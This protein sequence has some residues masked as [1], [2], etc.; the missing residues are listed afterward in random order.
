[1]AGKIRNA[2]ERDLP[3]IVEIYNSSIPG[4]TATADL[5]PVSVDDRRSWFDSHDS[6][7]RPILVLEVD[8][9]IAGWASLTDFVEGRP[10][11]HATAE[12]SI[13][14]APPYQAL[15]YGRQLM[16]RIIEKCPAL[17]IDSLL[18]IYFEHNIAS[19]KLC[20]LYGFEE[21]GHLKDIADLD[22][23]RA[24]VK[25]GVKRISSSPA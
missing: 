22:G 4:H 11:Y 8:D 18:A 20:E 6:D 25:I 17:G 21:M 16:Q 23:E 15:G 9:N 1:M 14:I 3:A 7:R 24:G 19:Q 5:V 13:Y 10:A 2:A 12:I